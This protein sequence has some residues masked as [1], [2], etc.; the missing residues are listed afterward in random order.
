MSAATL[1]KSPDTALAPPATEF[2]V[3][4]RN[5][6]LVMTRQSFGCTYH[7]FRRAGWTDQQLVANGFARGF[8][9]PLERHNDGSY[10]QKFWYWLA[11]NE[12]IWDSFVA[13]ARESKNSGRRR[14]SARAIVERMRWDAEITKGSS[15]FKMSDGATPYLSRLL[16]A[17]YPSEFAGYF[18]T[19]D[20]GAHIVTELVTGEEIGPNAED[21]D[22]S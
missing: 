5:V 8:V 12:H 17:E 16:M 2:D 21:E 20:R 13:W 11:L 19:H 7:A 18:T 22:V 6:G 9:H 4:A 10:P 14:Y 1:T 3:D 15:K